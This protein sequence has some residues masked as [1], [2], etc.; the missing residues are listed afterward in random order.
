[1]EQNFKLVLSYDGTVYH[2]WQLQPQKKT[3]QGILEEILFRF[4]SKRYPV[5]GAGRTDAGVHALG[6]QLSSQ[7]EIPHG[8]AMAI[9]MPVVMEFGS[10]ARIASASTA[11]KTA[12]PTG[13][14]LHRWSQGGSDFYPKAE[15][16]SGIRPP[17][18]QRGSIW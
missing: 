18:W 13:W 14:P 9:M 10:L 6:H 5:H 7:Y 12:F 4:Q 2:G 8:E 16:W 1:M 3:I 15:P 11:L 17:L